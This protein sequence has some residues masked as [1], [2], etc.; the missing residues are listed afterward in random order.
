[1]VVVVVE[2]EGKGEGMGGGGGGDGGS[3][4]GHSHRQQQQQPAIQPSAAAARR[5]SHSVLSGPVSGEGVPVH[6]STQRS[7]SA[8]RG[9]LRITAVC[10][11]I[12]ANIYYTTRH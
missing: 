2:E 8:A 12:T 9:P 3:R 1:M 10:F 4:A 5:V 6:R 7:V 11:D